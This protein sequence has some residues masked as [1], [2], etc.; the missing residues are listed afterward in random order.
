MDITEKEFLKGYNPGDY[1]RVSV[2][3]DTLLFTVTSRVN[4]DIRKLD[5]KELKVLLIKRKEHPFKDSWAFPGGFV[6]QDES[7]D[8][9]VGRK[10][11]EETN[12][13][14]IYFEQ[15]YTYGAVNRDPRMRVIS[16]AYMALIPDQN[17]KPVPGRDEAEVQWFSISKAPVSDNKWHL[18]LDSEEGNT[19]ILY[20]V[21]DEEVKRGVSKETITTVNPK[22]ISKE[23]LAFDHYRILTDAL[24][25]MKNKIEYTDLAFNLVGERFTRAE[26]Q[27]IYE[28]IL[29]RKF[30]R[31]ELWR[32]IKDMVI[33]TDA[34][35]SEKGYRPSKYYI[36]NSDWGNKY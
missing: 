27:S 29:D 12:L 36:F 25:R 7:L 35:K 14:D 23:T 2:T 4:E 10:L 22:A 16:T 15:L 8:E 34:V 6:R 30:T 3:V 32:K 19:T 11:E 9:A 31:M 26:I 24:M 20:E 17:L 1:D 18:R 13:K 28:L 33:E 21:T 5:E